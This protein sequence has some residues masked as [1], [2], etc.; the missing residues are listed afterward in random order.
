MIRNKGASH[1]STIT[2]TDDDLYV[3]TTNL[4]LLTNLPPARCV[5][6]LFP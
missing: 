5:S 1:L 4:S 3:L 2:T 6:L